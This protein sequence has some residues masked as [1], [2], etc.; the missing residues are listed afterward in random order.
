[1]REIPHPPLDL[2]ELTAAK[3]AAATFFHTPTWAGIIASEYPEFRVATRA[4]EL[5][6]HE[7]ALIPMVASVER[8]RFFIWLESMY[9]GGYGGIIATRPLSQDEV[10]EI[11]KRLLRRNVASLH[12]IGNPFDDPYDPPAFTKEPNSTHLLTLGDYRFLYDNFSDD[13]KRNITKAHRLGVAVTLAESLAD[14]EAYYRVYED[15]IRRWGETTLVTY[16]FSLFRKLY[17][18]QGE[19]IK[20]WLAKEDGKVISGKVVFYHNSRAFY[21]H[22]ATLEQYFQHYPDPLLMSA[23]IQDACKKNYRCLDL[24]PSAGLEGLERYKEKFGAQKAPFWSYT[25]Q[26]NKL[27]HL[28]KKV[29]GR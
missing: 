15:T 5:A 11:Y 6:D 26:A 12:I 14:Y 8:N 27:H 3:S 21:W 18:H 10:S 13:K 29:L 4:F 28:Y 2:W 23:I 9:Q 16:P 1:M 17:D 24:G 7:I 19:A 20:L 22:G 25:W